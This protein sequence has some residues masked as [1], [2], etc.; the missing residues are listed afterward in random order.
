MCRIFKYNLRMSESTLRQLKL[1]QILPREPL[2]ISPSDILKNLENSGFNSSIRTIQRDLNTLSSVLPLVCDNRNKP[3]GWSWHKKASGLNPAMDPIEALTFSLAEE[4][5]KP[6]MPTKSFKRMKIFFD[7]ANN[8][9]KEMDKSSIKNWRDSVRV[10]PQWQALIPPKID[11]KTEAIIYDAVLNGYKLITFYKKRGE[12]KFEKRIINPLGIVLQGVVHSLICTMQNDPEKPRHLPIHR[13]KKAKLSSQKVQKPK[14]FIIDEFIQSQN[15]G[16]LIN[17]KPV[18]LEAIFQP[19]A[20]FHLTETPISIDQ[21]LTRLKDGSYL[22]KANLPNTSQLRW[23]LLGFGDQ[24][25]IKR[26]KQLR[27]EFKMTASNMEKIYE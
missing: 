17:N 16:F 7:R 21:K 4:Y 10:V 27:N 11:D 9:L 1:L 20:G 24:V 3:F 25:E 5:L 18:T 22:L 12:R 19:M 2:K 23:W 15:I 8:I 13:F 14:N 6:I 26:P